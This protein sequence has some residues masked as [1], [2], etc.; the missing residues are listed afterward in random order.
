MAS[1]ALRRPEVAFGEIEVRK[2]P[3]MVRRGVRPAV[4]LKRSSS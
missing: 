3:P 4:G 1:H 2:A